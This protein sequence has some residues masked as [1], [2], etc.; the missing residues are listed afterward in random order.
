VATT[1]GGKELTEGWKKITELLNFKID[2][3]I[4]IFFC[5]RFF[6]LF[7]IF[8]VDFF[9]SFFYQNKICCMTMMMIGLVVVI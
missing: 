6:K 8:F 9:K 1:L 3:L 7:Y 2:K 5:K 4:I